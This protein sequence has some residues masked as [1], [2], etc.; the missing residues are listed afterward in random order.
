M[1]ETINYENSIQIPTRSR[2]LTKLCYSPLPAIIVYGKYKAE[3]TDKDILDYYRTL[4]NDKQIMEEDL[5]DVRILY[6]K[7]RGP[8]KGVHIE[9]SCFY[10]I[11]SN[12]VWYSTYYKGYEYLRVS[13]LGVERYYLDDEGNRY[14]RRTLKLIK[15]EE[16]EE[17]E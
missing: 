5:Y 3:I 2:C 17:E 1:L 11:P 4:L 6:D 12:R 14:D 10:D 9:Y 7:K 15:V 16:K 8:D 13:R